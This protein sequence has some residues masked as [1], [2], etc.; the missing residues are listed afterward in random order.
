[1]QPEPTVTTIP[2]TATEQPGK[3]TA[4]SE[5]QARPTAEEVAPAS[6][7]AEKTVAEVVV[8]IDEVEPVAAQAGLVIAPLVAPADEV[9]SDAELEVS[10]AIAPRALDLMD[11]FQKEY[12]EVAVDPDADPAVAQTGSLDQ[13]PVATHDRLG[14][15]VGEVKHFAES[16]ISRITVADHSLLVSFLTNFLWG[17][18]SAL[19]GCSP[20]DSG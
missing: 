18:A 10:N 6:A 20:R 7:A 8:I 11:K 2:P 15:V 9:A 17:R 3:P 13:L 14:A 16:L 19:T 4:T 1:M 5:S 12:A